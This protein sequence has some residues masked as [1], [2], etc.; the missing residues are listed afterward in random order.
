MQGMALE[1]SEQD[2]KSKA[3]GERKSTFEFLRYTKSF[4]ELDVSSCDQ[5]LERLRS[6]KQRLENATDKLAELRGQLANAESMFAAT[7]EALE[8]L[9]RALG[10]TEKTQ[11]MPSEPGLDLRIQ[12]VGAIPADKMALTV[13]SC[14]NHERSTREEFQR[15]I[16]A[17]A[18]RQEHLRDRIR[19]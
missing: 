12:E 5:T 11:L 7:E 14:E 18:K 4:S 13:E 6:E 19:D 8:K 16:D 15:R 1:I 10:S 3:A 9:Q 17:E 2:Q